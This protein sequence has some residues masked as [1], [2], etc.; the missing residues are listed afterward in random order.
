MAVKGSIAKGIVGN[1]I[2]EVFGADYVGE[3]SGKHYVWATENGE[4]VQ[5]AIA[6]TCPKTPVGEVPQTAKPV[7]SGSFNW[8]DSTESTTTPAVSNYKPA[9]ITE[10]EKAR[11]AELM[12]KLNL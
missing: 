8:D 2:A 3:I 12:R 4:R 5:I 9:E 1:K 10:D 7:S 11:V 6:L